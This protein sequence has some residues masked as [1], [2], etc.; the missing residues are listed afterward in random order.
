M[1]LSPTSAFFAPQTP[2]L[3]HVVVACDSR[4]AINTNSVPMQLNEVPAR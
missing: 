3:F 4:V 2:T 1:E